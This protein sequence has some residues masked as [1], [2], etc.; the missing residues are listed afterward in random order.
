MKALTLEIISWIYEEKCF[1]WKGNTYHFQ[2]ECTEPL[3]FMVP[4]YSSSISSN[5]PFLKT[6]VV[7]K[8]IRKNHSALIVESY[9][10]VGHQWKLIQPQIKFEEKWEIIPLALLVPEKRHSKVREGNTTYLVSILQG[11][12]SVF[13]DNIVLVRK[14]KRNSSSEQV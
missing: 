2:K 8:R 11:A 5:R 6:E 3:I 12:G 10:I 13:Y 1:P 7:G 14:E 9:S 4:L